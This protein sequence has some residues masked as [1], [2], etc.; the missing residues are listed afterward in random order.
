MSFVD[1]SVVTQK[2]VVSM[3]VYLLALCFAL[4]Y[5]LVTFWP[6]PSPLVISTIEPSQAH[7]LDTVTIQG[8]GFTNGIIVSFDDIGG[9]IYKIENT[10]VVVKLPKH[11]SGKSRVVVKDLNGQ[12]IAI[13]D[14]FTFTSAAALS[15]ATKQSTGA[16]T[17]AAGASASGG[18]D[19]KQAPEQMKEYRALEGSNL[20][21]I[22]FLSLFHF[23]LRDNVRVLL[24][25][26]IVG[27][28]GG[29]MHVFRSFYWYVGNRT[30]K[31]SWLLM[32][33]L[34]PFSGAGL[35]V[36]FYLIIRGGISSQA[37]T[38]PS[39]LDGYA[40]MSALV[41]MFSQEALL[42]LKQ[43]AAAFFTPAEAGKD[44]AIPLLQ[45]KGI[46]PAVGPIGGGT[47]VT[48][49]GTGFASGNQVTFGGIPAA[50]VTV[51]SG[52]QLIAITPPHAA[53]I[54]D[55]E[56]SNAAGQKSSLP[57]SFTYQ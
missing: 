41:G 32:Y 47:S 22:S 33:I 8:S 40:A 15:E 48:I 35:A 45:I 7:P 28:L 16:I 52:S 53:G 24:I 20:S 23:W 55:I 38:N 42:K 19:L 36:L 13:P 50:S 17:T 54:V 56:L 18:G 2:A 39:S 51:A 10:S 9:T 31:N 57:K 12:T 11:D 6:S 4:G 1:D 21:R 25:V 5:C 34:L 49:T 27:A 30:L 29:L 37:P 26:M 14:A 44:P 43:I 46:T 3:L